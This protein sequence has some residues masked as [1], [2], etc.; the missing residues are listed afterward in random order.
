MRQFLLLAT[1]TFSTL[2]LLTGCEKYR[3][4]EEVRKLCAKDGGITVHETVKL[5]EN[6]FNE[7]GQVSFYQARA[8]SILLTNY[9]L[10][11]EERIFRSGD[12]RMWRTYFAIKR[13]NDGKVLG[14]SV[15]YTR[16][17]DGFEGPF[18]PSSFSCPE[19]FGETSLLK[20]VFANKAPI[21]K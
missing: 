16:S 10:I 19:Q 17:G 8:G 21:S 15:G 3:L 9:E 12:P 14:E 6:E 4:D 1:A 7:F 20:L 11:K 2:V 13:R 5:P 18:H